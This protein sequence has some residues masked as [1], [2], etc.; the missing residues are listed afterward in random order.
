M[1]GFLGGAY[2]DQDSPLQGESG[3]FVFF[4]VKMAQRLS[5]SIAGISNSKGEEPARVEEA[6]Q[7][8][9]VER[10]RNP[11]LPLEQREKGEVAIFQEL[12]K[13]LTTSLQ[14]EQVSAP[15]Q[16]VAAAAG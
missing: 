13:A 3:E 10:R 6:N 7:F 9:A 14:L 1:H 16:L 5:E 4:G 15:G 8:P 12:G 11:G 2:T